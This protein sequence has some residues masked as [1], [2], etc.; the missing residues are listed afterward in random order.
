MSDD[1]PTPVVAVHPERDDQNMLTVA[2]PPPLPIAATGLR[3]ESD[4]E[5]S[6]LVAANTESSPEELLSAVAPRIISVEMV[7]QQLELASPHPTFSPEDIASILLQTTS[8]H[9]FGIDDPLE[10]VASTRGGDSHGVDLS[11]K[12]DQSY[13]HRFITAS[14]QP[15]DGVNFESF[16]KDRPGM[17]TGEVS[18]GQPSIKHPIPHIEYS[19]HAHHPATS[20]NGQSDSLGSAMVRATPT[21]ERARLEA[22]NVERLQHFSLKPL[23]SAHLAPDGF[24]HDPFLLRTQPKQ[25]IAARVDHLSFDTTVRRVPRS[26]RSNGVGIGLRLFSW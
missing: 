21:V 16:Q 1:E 12:A 15:S 5:F 3:W 17:R 24:R 2:P 18:G 22:P 13:R 11:A 10:E 9:P 23:Q 25:P 6:A 26:T 20:R 14:Q 8:P 19:G 4:D 7:V